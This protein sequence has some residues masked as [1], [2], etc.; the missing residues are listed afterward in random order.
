M[1][2]F[3]LGNNLVGDRSMTKSNANYDPHNSE[4]FEAI[5]QAIETALYYPSLKEL[6]H[7]DELLPSGD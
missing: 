5:T 3:R 6:G 7:D 2:S 4:Q 1:I